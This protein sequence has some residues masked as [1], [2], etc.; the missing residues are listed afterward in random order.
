MK[1]F[2]KFS[3]L[4]GLFI[5][6]SCSKEIPEDEDWCLRDSYKTEMNVTVK[7]DD[8]FH[9]YA[10]IDSVFS[11]RSS[12]TDPLLKYYLIAV[13]HNSIIKPFVFSSFSN[14]VPVMLVPGKYSFVGWADYEMPG[15]STSVNF[16]TDDINELLLK[17]KYNYSGA[18]RYKLGFRGMKESSIAYNTV[19]DSVMVNPAM[20]LYRL[21]ATD[22]ADYIPSKVVVKYT[23]LLPSAINGVTGAINWWWDDISFT[24]PVKDTLG[25]NV[26]LLASDYVFSQDTETSVTVTVEIY[27]DADILRAR[28]TNLKIP[29]V[30]GGITTVKGNFFSYLELDKGSGGGAGI[31]IKT[32]WDATFEI[33]L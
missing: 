7:L 13:P 3:L 25:G 30:N 6:V 1:P 21:E 11:T 24:N 23:S 27:D 33:E 20:G 14:K 8:S 28:K 32:E 12:D 4:A 26:Q 19:K 17:N 22:T 15:S 29:L 5:A 18:S 31:S 2:V 16:Y 9:K 10:T